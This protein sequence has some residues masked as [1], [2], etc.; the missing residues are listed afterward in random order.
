MP[1]SKYLPEHMG[2]ITLSPPDP[3][4]AG[5]YVE[6]TLVYTAGNVRH[7]PHRHGEKYRGAP[8][9]IFAKPQFTRPDA[10]NFTTVEASN[11]AKLE[12]WFDR[13]NIRPYA[14][15]VLIRIG[16]GYLRAGDTLTIR[17][18]DRRQGLPPGSAPQTKFVEKNVELR[19]FG[20]CV[21]DLRILRAAAPAGIRSRGRSCGAAG[22]RSCRR[23]P[24]IGRA[25]SASDR[26]RRTFGQSDRR[27]RCGCLT[28][29]T[30]ATRC[31]VCRSRSRSTKATA[32]ASSTASS[33]R[34]LAIFDLNVIAGGETVWRVRI[35][36]GV[37]SASAQ[38]RSWGGSARPKRW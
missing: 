18:G 16:R 11:G 32:R 13:L 4:V 12:V 21:R 25:V 36:C 20:R 33:Q 24:L 5:S 38:R 9:R 15:T 27:R 28:F 29:E 22:R 34:R 17:L 2:A 37:V 31:A 10:P 6:L 23:L 1:Y 30:N 7:R 14:N 35:R 19:S 26:R 3:F 8:R